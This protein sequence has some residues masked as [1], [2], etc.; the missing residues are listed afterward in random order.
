MGAGSLPKISADAHVNEPHNLWYELLPPGLREKS[1]HHIQTESDGGWRL[2]V[3]ENVDVGRGSRKTAVRANGVEAIDTDREAEL[4]PKIR[5][6]M[7]KTDGINGEII[8]PT[9][10]LYAYRVKDPEVGQLCCT[11]YND[12][13]YERL[14][15]R[16][17]RIRVAILIPTWDVEMAISEVR[18]WTNKESVG[19]MFIPLVGTPEW[20]HPQWEPMWT[21]IEEAGETIAM[22]QSTGHE[23]WYAGI[24]AP[25]ANLMY[26]QTMAPRT[27]ALLAGSGILERHPKLHF[28]LV[29][30]N[31]GWLAATMNSLDEWT[32]SLEPNFHAKMPNLSNEPSYF[33]KRQVHATFMNDPIAVANR[34]YTGIDCLLWGNDF[35]HYEG[36]YPNS[37]KVLD[38]L[39]QGVSEDD[40]LQILAGNTVDLFGFDPSIL[41]EAVS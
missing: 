38:E 2:V 21:A 5:L 35:P 24:G 9:I 11:A 7:M 13:I 29:E 32:R 34:S 37:T 39:L 10:G 20:N 31:A 36:T 12:W 3:N 1:P 25:P 26:M 28:V 30:V 8:Y 14:G 15:E 18:R 4:R 23:H 41:T 19:A 22:H 16:T 6:E 33:L 17:P 40:A 27:C